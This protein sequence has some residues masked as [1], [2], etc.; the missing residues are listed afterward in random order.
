MKVEIIRMP[1]MTIEEF[2]EQYKLTL[3]VTERAGGEFEATLKGKKVDP[4]LIGH[5]MSP[6]TAVVDFAKRISG[7][8][9]RPRGKRVVIPYLTVA[10]FY[11]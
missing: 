4:D 10:G 3:L 8:H 2:A 5:G 7:H 9:L 1:K 11:E 6:H